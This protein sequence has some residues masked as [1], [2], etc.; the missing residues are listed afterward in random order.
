MNT[1]DSHEARR[2]EQIKGQISLAKII[3]QSND[4]NNK[5]SLDPQTRMEQVKSRW[6]ENTFSGLPMILAT[7]EVASERMEEV[8]TPSRLTLVE[9]LRH[10]IFFF[11]LFV[12]LFHSLS[13]TRSIPSLLFGK[14]VS[15]QLYSIFNLSSKALFIIRYGPTFQAQFIRL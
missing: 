15:D 10:G 12:C 9:M 2:G 7:E 14:A 11:F 13:L 5:Q 6:G 1:R 8:S 3:T 4:N